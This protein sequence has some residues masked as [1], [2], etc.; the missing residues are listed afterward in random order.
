MLH[1][2]GLGFAAWETNTSP[3][4]KKTESQNTGPNTRDGKNVCGD[5]GTRVYLLFC[6]TSL[7]HAVDSLYRYN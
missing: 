3:I 5:F 2:S 7:K 4:N 1:E 6:F